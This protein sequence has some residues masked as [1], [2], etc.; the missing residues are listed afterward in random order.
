MKQ[1]RP[2]RRQGARYP[3]DH[4][5]SALRKRRL[6]LDLQ[7]KDLAKLAATSRGHLCELEKG[8][9]NPSQDLL[10]RLAVALDC[11][12]TSL[13]AKSVEVS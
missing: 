6:E 2:N 1:P 13:Q 8:V 4:D 3:L 11:P 9:R 12:V 10:H 7:Q 5:P